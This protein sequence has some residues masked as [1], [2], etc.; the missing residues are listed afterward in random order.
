ML[1]GV[2]LDQAMQVAT[3][4]CRRIHRL[5]IPIHGDIT[6]SVS[7]GIAMR[8]ADDSLESLVERADQAMYDAKA[9]GRNQVRQYE[10]HRAQPIKRSRLRSVADE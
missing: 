6:L 7:I 4:L 9:S 1:G 10:A 8:L 5:E 2:E 3:R